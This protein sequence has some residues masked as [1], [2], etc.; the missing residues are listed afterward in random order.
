MNI[1]LTNDDGIHAPGLRCLYRS[2]V[3]AGHNV[4]VVAPLTEQ[5]AV[6]HSVTIFSPVRV[7]EIKEDG[8]Q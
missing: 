4:F 5:S 3:K 7:K 2:L 6:G 8:F 1:L